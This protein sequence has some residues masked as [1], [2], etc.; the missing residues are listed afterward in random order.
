MIHWLVSSQTL[1]INEISQGVTGA[2][3][4]VELSWSARLPVHPRP[5]LI[6]GAGTLMTTAGFSTV[7]PVRELRL[8]VSVSPMIPSGPAWKPG[9]MILIYN[10]MDYDGTIIPPADPNDSNHD[11]VYVV[12]Q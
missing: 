6:S 9:T 10:D 11:C 2:K 4:Y 7:L 1:M 8:A 12:S 5:A 3:E